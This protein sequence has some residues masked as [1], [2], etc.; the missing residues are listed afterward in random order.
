[1]IN[2]NQINQKQNKYFVIIFFSQIKIYYS[3]RKARVTP[4]GQNC[5]FQLGDKFRNV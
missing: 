5:S 3:I 1:M 4:C 2:I